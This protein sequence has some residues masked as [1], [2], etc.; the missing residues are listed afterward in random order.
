M[1]VLHPAI[2]NANLR[3]LPKDP[4]LMQPVHARRVVRRVVRRSRVIT[5]R[6]RDLDGIKLDDMV[7]PD[8]DDVREG[9]EAGHVMCFGLDVRPGE[10]VVLERLDDFDVGQGGD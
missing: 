1:G 9:L 8:L 4:I 10:D 3:A 2:H 7:M 5:E 6:P